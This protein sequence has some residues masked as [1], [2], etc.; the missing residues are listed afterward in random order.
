MTS[1]IFFRSLLICVIASGCKKFTD[2]NA[3]S[4]QLVTATVFTSDATLKSAIAGMYSTIAATNAETMQYELSIL[5]STSAD[6]IRYLTT[7]ISYDPFTNNALTT[8]DP[9]V[10]DMWTG[11]YNTNYYAN[12]LIAGV[13]GSTGGL[14]DSLSRETIAEGKFIRAFCH[15]YLVN[16][17]GDVPIAT[18][19]NAAINNALSRSP[20]DSV[21]AQIIR[22][23]KDAQAGMKADYSYANGERTRPNKYAAAALLSRAYLY[24]SDWANAE[25]AATTLINY[26]SLYKLTDI[27]N[28]FIKNNTE[29][30]WQMSSP[31][32]TGY[33]LEGQ[34]YNYGA[35]SSS[36]NFVLTSSL[37]A[38][39][40]PGDLRFTNWVNT[41]TYTDDTITYYYPYKYKQRTTNTSSAGEY[42]TPL[43]LGEQYLIRAEARANQ[44]NLTGAIE[45][46]NVIRTRAG[47]A[48]TTAVSLSDV[49]TAIEQ[50]RR[51]EL[52]CEYGHRWYDLKRTN[53][54]DAVLGADK[55]G[56]TSHAALFPIPQLER[57]NNTNLTQNNGY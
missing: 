17:Y 55:S 7:D 51:I 49:L 24:T 38:A 29:A 3:P 8:D 32:F 31:V 40:E 36:P 34:Y 30:I 14:S 53:R 26:S 39:F 33:T 23:L 48:N 47:L 25:A 20:K 13:Q 46:I 52:F 35:Y 1:N 12:S 21:Y 28:T 54:A 2:V 16:L 15:F 27:S 50:E 18:T 44:K 41:E 4:S 6:E 43:R 42:W 56:W 45:D 57:N 9:Y 19:T 10:L 37:L 11:L 5:P 22:D